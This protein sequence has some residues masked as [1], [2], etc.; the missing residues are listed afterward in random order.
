[1][2]AKQWWPTPLV[3]QALGKQRQVYLYDFEASQVYRSSFRIAEA[4]LSQKTK[5]KMKEEGRGGEGRGGE[6]RGGEGRG[7]EGSWGWQDGSA[8]SGIH[9]QA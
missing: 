1:M 9:H 6:G 4:T 2:P 7:G 3:L 5:T 8:N